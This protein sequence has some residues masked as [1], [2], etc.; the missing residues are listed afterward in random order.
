MKADIFEI[1]GLAMNALG[2]RGNPGG[3]L[4]GLGDRHHE[5]FDETP[6]YFGGQP[7]ANMGIPFG[8]GTIFPSGVT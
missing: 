2:R 1:D 7:I 4:A 8:F 3:H 5:G 6:V